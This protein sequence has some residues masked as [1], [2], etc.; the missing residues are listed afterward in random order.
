[1]ARSGISEAPT[2]PG[3]SQPRNTNPVNRLHRFFPSQD[4][5]HIHFNTFNI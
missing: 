2:P 5:R 1:M 4:K 3:N